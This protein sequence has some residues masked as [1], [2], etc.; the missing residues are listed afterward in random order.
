MKDKNTISFQLRV[1][2]FFRWLVVVGV[3]SFLGLIS[4]AALN[5]RVFVSASKP[6]RVLV[7]QLDS[8]TGLLTL[9]N[10][11]ETSNAPGS[12]CFSGSGDRL[13]VSLKNPG[14]IAVFEW[15]EGSELT[16]LGEVE[17]GAYAGYV[18]VHRSG[19]FL[20]GSYYAAGQVTVHR[21]QDNGTL[22][23]DPIQTVKTDDNAHAV[24]T[25]PSGQF[26]FVPHTRPNKIY[27]FRINPSSGK[28]VAN[29]T[30]ILIRNSDTGPR[31][32]WFHPN[33]EMAYGSDEQGSSISAYELKSKE[34]TLS[35]I[36]T[37]SSLPSDFK[38]Q[39]STSDIEV[40]PSGKF[41]YIANRGHNSIA[42]FAIDAM[43]GRLT[44]LEHAAVDPVPRSFNITPNGDFLIVAG[45]QTNN[46]KVFRIGESGGL[47]H[48]QT[49]SVQ[50]DPWWVVWQPQ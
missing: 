48:T 20:F 27:Q 1:R 25:D 22:S 3:V 32:L 35:L 24:V 18:R 47:I 44:F 16:L 10:E 36:E 5:Q 17:T 26:L 40:H 19:D 23:S 37:H 33:L 46:L 8:D 21:I 43:N 4:Q 15:G 41:V 6:D 9:E 50:G 14:S 45:Q 28:L 2:P 39:N 11:V 42:G 12:L 49:V 34:G 29:E 7:Y 13:Y 38:D 30:P 31:H